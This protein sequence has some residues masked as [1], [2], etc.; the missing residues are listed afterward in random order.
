MEAPQI[1]ALILFAINLLIN[2]N[3][4]NK[5][6]PDFNFWTTLISVILNLTLLYWGGFF[7]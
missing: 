6:R 1:I 7:K 2:A 3:M 5:P 4:H